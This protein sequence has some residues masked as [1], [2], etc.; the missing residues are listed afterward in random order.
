ML[1]DAQ[2]FLHFTQAPGGII[3]PDRATLYVCA[4]E[5][6]QYKDEK[7]NCKSI[8]FSNNFISFVSNRT[9]LS[10][11]VLSSKTHYISI[12]FICLNSRSLFYI[13]ISFVV[14]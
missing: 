3:M 9:C 12:K 8:S 11:M 13:S 5:D 10:S 1:A 6:R 4:I 14:E 7:I 2:N